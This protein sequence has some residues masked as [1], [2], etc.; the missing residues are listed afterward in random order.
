M[1]ARN[2]IPSLHKGSED[3]VASTYTKRILNY[4]KMYSNPR[5]R[6]FLSFKYAR[7][8]QIACYPN[9][10]FSTFNVPLYFE[11]SKAV[12]PCLTDNVRSLTPL[13]DD[14]NEI[15]LKPDLRLDLFRLMTQ[16]FYST[17]AS[18]YKILVVLTVHRLL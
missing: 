15:D 10:T 5:L 18:V 16:Y 13:N 6:F 7:P 14:E 8:L 1:T 17:L 9:P 12:V 4:F 2:S 11:S 3:V